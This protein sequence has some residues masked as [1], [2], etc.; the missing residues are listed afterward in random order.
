MEIVQ[1]KMHRVALF[2]DSSSTVHFA[3]EVDDNALSDILILQSARFN[4]R[5]LHSGD[6]FTQP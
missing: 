5:E 1:F 6:N 2:P 4:N 3:M